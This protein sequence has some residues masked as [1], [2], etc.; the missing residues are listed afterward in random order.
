M[1]FFLLSLISIRHWFCSALPSLVLVPS[2]WAVALSSPHWS[3][4]SILLW[5]GSGTLADLPDSS[6]FWQAYL[7]SSPQR[8]LSQAQSGCAAPCIA[9]GWNWLLPYCSSIF[10]PPL[11][12]VS[13][14]FQI[15]QYHSACGSWHI[16]HP[17]VT[18]TCAFADTVPSAQI[19]VT[20]MPSLNSYS[21]LKP[22]LTDVIL[23]QA[24]CDSPTSANWVNFCALCSTTLPSST[25]THSSIALT[26]LDWNGLFCSS[27]P[28][29][30]ML[31]KAGAQGFICLCS[32]VP[33]R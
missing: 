31:L 30:C 4:R 24:L 7:P 32:L 16:P 15:L 9:M 1:Q 19:S 13:L 10:H 21:S 18:H 23:S 33:E 6:C 29:V 12:C 11:P 2:C 28:G 26:A 17:A 25:P 20:P 14:L 3:R 22:P 27:H 5:L 8:D